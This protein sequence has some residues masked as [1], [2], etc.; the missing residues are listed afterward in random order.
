[1]MTLLTFLLSF[2]DERPLALQFAFLLAL[3]GFLSTVIL[4]RLLK[5]S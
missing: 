4:S 5:P 3:L 2:Y 1:M